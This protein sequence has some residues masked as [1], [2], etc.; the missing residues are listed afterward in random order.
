MLVKQFL[1]AA[2]VHV[3]RTADVGARRHDPGCADAQVQPAAGRLG[4]QDGGAARSLG[5]GWEGYLGYG[6]ADHLDV[7]IL[8]RCA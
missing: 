8:A 1:L 2:E 7:L 6:A 3:R 4:A 5:W